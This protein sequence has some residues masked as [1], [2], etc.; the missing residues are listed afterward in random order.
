MLCPAQASL[1]GPVADPLT[2]G[3]CVD[4]LSSSRSLTEPV[5]DLLIG[6]ECIDALSSSSLAD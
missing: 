4:A 5:V 2:V 1:T 6:S 3:E